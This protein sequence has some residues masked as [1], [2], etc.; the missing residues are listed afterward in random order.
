MVPTACHDGL[1][2]P[3]EEKAKENHDDKDHEADAP[4]PGG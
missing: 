4:C 1:S 2:G 3:R